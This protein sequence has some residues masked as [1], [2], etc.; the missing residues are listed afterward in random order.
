MDVSKLE[1]VHED[2]Y[3]FIENAA[4]ANL[5]VQNV[6]EDVLK[7]LCNGS[8]ILAKNLRL[9]HTIGQGKSNQHV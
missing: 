8:I 3:T 2:F 6:Q 7:S 9:R 5:C 4:G 1:I